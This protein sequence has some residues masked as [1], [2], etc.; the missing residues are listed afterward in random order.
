MARKQPDNDSYKKVFPCQLRNLMENTTHQE[1]A[2][3]L[4]KTRQAVSYYL[5]GSSSPDWE[6]IV[7]ISDYFDVSIDYLLRGTGDPKR[8]PTAV[9]ELGLSNN[10][11]ENILRWKNNIYIGNALNKKS[12][13]YALSGL[14][15]LIENGEFM[16]LMADIQMLH[17]SISNEIG[18]L[19]KY[20]NSTNPRE[21]LEYSYLTDEIAIATEIEEIIAEQR[22]E[23]IGR[24]SVFTGYHYIESEIN[25]IVSRFD[26]LVRSV[27]EYGNYHDSV[28]LRK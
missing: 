13:E 20:H 8:Q 10:A 2:D 27:I 26:R 24:F 4:G 21:Q 12:N 22:P 18:I 15:S 14:C 23:Y 17:N 5:D 11:I 19:Q 25:A 9:D 16:Q 6:T 7:K 3:Y 1:L 28:W